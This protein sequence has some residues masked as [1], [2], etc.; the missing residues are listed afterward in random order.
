MKPVQGINELTKKKVN[1]GID[2]HLLF[3]ASLSASIAGFV[4]VLGRSLLMNE[5]E[6]GALAISSTGAVGGLVV[7]PIPLLMGR[8][9][10]RMGRKVYLYL[11]YLACTAGLSVLAISTSLW[12]FYI[13]LILQSLF[14]GIN[15]TNGNALVTDLVHR[16]SLGRGPFLFGAT[17]CHNSH[18]HH[19]NMSD[20]RCIRINNSHP[21]RG[22][23]TRDD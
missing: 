17:A 14:V 16:E 11:G 8:L 12:N 4:I 7:M 23:R 18:I 19:R 21:F 20:S 3:S 10:D 13:V 9:S 22:Q 1:L 6:F 5:L 15:G 2:Y